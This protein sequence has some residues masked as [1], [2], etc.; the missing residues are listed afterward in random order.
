MLFF[1]N[2][3]IIRQHAA[4][5]DV[6]FRTEKNKYKNRTAEKPVIFAIGDWVL[7]NTQVDIDQHRVQSKLDVNWVGPYLVLE[8][9]PPYSYKLQHH[10][11][12]RVTKPIHGRLLRKYYMPDVPIVRA[13]IENEHSN[14][15]VDANPPASPAINQHRRST[16]ER[17]QPRTMAPMINSEPQWE[18]FDHLLVRRTSVLEP[19]ELVLDKRGRSVKVMTVAA[20]SQHIW[21][22]NST[23]DIFRINKKDVYCRVSKTDVTFRSQ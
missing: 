4:E 19:G 17:R 21:V 15:D 23:D 9:I 5:A 1:K 8:L 18:S 16:R 7:L 10:D 20:S 12:Q 13:P 22:K 6:E 2:L 14:N 3:R 11:T